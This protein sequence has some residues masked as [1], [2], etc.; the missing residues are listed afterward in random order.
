MQMLISLRYPLPVVAKVS[1][2]VESADALVANLPRSR[3]VEQVL[4]EAIEKVSGKRLSGVDLEHLRLSEA[5]M[6][7][8]YHRWEEKSLE[9]AHA[10]AA[11][12]RTQ[13]VITSGRLYQPLT[14]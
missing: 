6:G 8:P 5:L 9:L 11:A 1:A 7:T 12:D 2:L 4:I 3:E 10:A 14:V 13:K